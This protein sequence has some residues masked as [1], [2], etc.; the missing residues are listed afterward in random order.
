MVKVPSS[1]TF[2]DLRLKKKKTTKVY[3]R[4]FAF[5]PKQ[6]LSPALST[7]DSPGCPTLC[8]PKDYFSFSLSSVVSFPRASLRAR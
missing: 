8:D 2:L 7:S 3:E 1:F 5:L 4:S 6:V